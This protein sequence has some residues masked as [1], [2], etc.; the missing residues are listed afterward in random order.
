MGTDV[1]RTADSGELSKMVTDLE[2][3]SNH[4][5][6]SNQHMRLLLEILGLVQGADDL[7]AM[8][9]IILTCVTSGYSLGFNRAFLFLLDKG[10]RSLRGS[11]AVGPK[12]VEEAQEI[13]KNVEEK[14]GGLEEMVSASSAGGLEGDREL[15]EM[16]RDIRI[17]VGDG[18]SLLDTCLS[19]GE[20]IVVTDLS[21]VNETDVLRRLGSSSFVCAPIVT[22]G[23]PIGVV[24]ADNMITGRVPSGEQVNLLRM[25]GNQVG[26]IVTHASHHD[27]IE[28]RLRELSTLNEVCKGILSTTDLETDLALIA[29]ISAQVL[30][31][32]G[33]AL[34][35]VEDDT[36][37]LVIQAF[38]GATAD[39]EASEAGA[40]AIAETVARDGKPLL[41]GSGTTGTETD[42]G[43]VPAMSLICV[44]LTKADRV[45]G[46]LTVFGRGETDS[47]RSGGFGQDDLRFLSVLGGQAAIAIEN[48]KLFG[49]LRKTQQRIRE[50]HEH[51]LRSERLAALGELSSQVAHEIRNPLT[52][53]GGFARSI[54]R[55]MDSDDPERDSIE[56]IIRETERLE[57]ILT[58]QLCFARISP[59]EFESDDI[60]KV[61]R[62]TVNLFAERIESRNAGLEMDLAEDIPMM[63][64]D[65]GKIKQ[66]LV[67]LVQNAIECISD[68]GNIRIS[69]N[70]CDRV[71]EVRVANDGP[72]IPPEILDRLFV[73]FA[74]T[75]ASGT[76]LG[77]AIASEI[78][79]EHGGT[80]DVSSG[81]ESGT[82]FLISLPLTL[83]GD[84]RRGPIDR[85]SVMRDRR[86]FSR[87]P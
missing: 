78:I 10:G 17:S 67:N 22:D 41:T 28:R 70:K 26:E 79:Y 21:V 27:D 49:S 31:A 60:N 43:I 9:S 23:R 30:N 14:A 75:K 16:V 34:R 68:G 83:E 38:Y 74:T 8:L 82:V 42:G 5:E 7:E 50:L 73:P 51:L 46:T 81:A 29:R 58:E 52:A 15:T 48:A 12:S 20:P 4:L 35:L 77:L 86:R 18:A 36:G 80:I 61:I 57:R 85:R 53:I 24:V 25:L 3:R 47:F 84:R 19:D 66:V 71:A 13:W 87:I 6:Q 37:A 69:S 54:E 62:E 56:T 44:P 39:E 32:T 59:P 72:P 45:I 76:G 2:T 55:Q 11:L 33:A 63:S 64:I 40:Q 1:D 65:P